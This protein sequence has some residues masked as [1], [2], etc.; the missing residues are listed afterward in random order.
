MKNRIF[1]LA[2]ALLC[3]LAICFSAV[4]A[5]SVFAEDDIVTES[6]T[7]AAAEPTNIAIGQYVE[8]LDLIS[9]VDYVNDGGTT[10]APNCLVDGVKG[11]DNGILLIPAQHITE[12]VDIVVYLDD[13]YEISSLATYQ[14]HGTNGAA[15][16]MAY[17]LDVSV[18]G[19]NWEPVASV[20]ETDV[21]QK[22]MVKTFDLNESVVAKYVR[23][24]ITQDSGYDLTSVGFGWTTGFGELEIYGVPYTGEVVIETETETD[25]PVVTDPETEAETVAETVA[26]TVAESEIEAD[27]ETVEVIVDETVGETGVEET[28]ADT[29]APT[30]P[31]TDDGCA[32]VVG[33]GAVAVLTAAAAAVV[34]KKKD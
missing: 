25:A 2:T 17:T 5:L 9:G 13:Y 27:S 12:P 24:H 18:D 21:I 20:T 29:A 28:V 6:E 10:W 16:P 33:F 1:L 19:R 23:I 15:L 3:A 26:D 32:S 7:D 34:L 14:P 11:Q 31:A 4:P 30:A 8:I 22:E